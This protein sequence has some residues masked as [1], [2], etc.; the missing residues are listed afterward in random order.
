M[1][2]FAEQTRRAR[3]GVRLTQDADPLTRAGGATMAD[4]LRSRAK[5]WLDASRMPLVGVT[6]CLIR[7]LDE[8][9]RDLRARVNAFEE[10]KAFA[11]MVGAS[12]GDLLLE[13]VDGWLRHAAD[14]H[15]LADAELCPTCDL[16]L[17]RIK[18]AHSVWRRSQYQAVTGGG[19]DGEVRSP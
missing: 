19:R 9:V 18:M 4:A 8:E 14:P 15:D 1:R 3:R 5:R 16:F 6:E 7:D 2:P 11:L 17:A 13:H 10:D 12:A